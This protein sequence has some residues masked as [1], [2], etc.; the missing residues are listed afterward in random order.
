M[1]VRVVGSAAEFA[2]AIKAARPGDEIAVAAGTYTDWTLL[3]PATTAGEPGRPVR[4]AAATTGAVTLTGASL[5]D[6]AGS[7]I[8]VAG[9]RFDATGAPSLRIR[10]S[11]NR[12]TGLEFQSAGTRRKPHA[13]ILRIGPG[14]SDN[15]IDH[16]LFVGSAS[17]SLQVKVSKDPGE[18]LPLRNHIHHNEF[19]D[20]PRYSPNGQEPIQIGQGPGS[21]H[22]LGTSVERNL[23]LR[24]D[25]DDELVSIKTSGNKVR[26]NV[27]EDSAGG[28]SLRGGGLNLVEGN[29]LL[30]T[31]RGIVVTGHRQTVINNFVDQ[32]RE[33]G[34]LVAVGSKRYR[35]ATS[36]VIAHN[37]V[38][39][40]DFPLRFSLRDPVMT[41]APQD[42]RIINNILVAQR[43]DQDIVSANKG[44]P[45]DLYMP[46]N[47]VQGNL[48]WWVG[49][50]GD[51]VP[52]RRADGNIIADPQLDLSDPRLPKLR[53]DS[54]A[55][56]N[57]LRDYA[58]ADMTGL[59]RSVAAP[60]DIGAVQSASP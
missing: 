34:I 2:A 39:R 23:F 42:N 51:G 26:F 13:P 16:C 56:G 20:I 53:R 5:I 46:S 7:H 49:G 48:F 9:F 18:G 60:P 3:I 28:I 38:I 21:H 52:V 29:V 45:A 47:L 33:E 43:A 11:S 8:E 37:T 40:A 6:V 25:G 22:I 35:A 50:R 4:V 36:C 32:P 57:G 31:K 44:Q 30:R 19:R 12:A 55:R 59:R 15:E 54:P 58:A 41:A 17:V 24:A 14:A 10:G 27:A 1:G